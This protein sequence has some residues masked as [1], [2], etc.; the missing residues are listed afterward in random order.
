MLP[1]F[2]ATNMTKLR[3]TNLLAPGPDTYVASAIRTIGY[4]RHTTGYWPHAL[5]QLLITSFHAYLP[6]VTNSIVLYFMRKI[7]NKSLKLNAKFKEENSKKEWKSHEQK[8]PKISACQRNIC[9]LIKWQTKKL[10]FL[11][12]FYAIVLMYF[13]ALFLHTFM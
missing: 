11:N 2:V 3:R 12:I 5:K 10:F 7:K 13:N 1:G 8:P 9:E 6:D 4:A